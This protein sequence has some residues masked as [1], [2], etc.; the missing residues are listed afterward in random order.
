MGKTMSPA[1]LFAFDARMYDL[2]TDDKRI[3]VPPGSPESEQ[4][5]V[6][7]PPDGPLGEPKAPVEDPGPAEP[8]RLRKAA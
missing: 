4:P 2:R 7:E 3:P 8:Q 5:P 6:E 1:Y